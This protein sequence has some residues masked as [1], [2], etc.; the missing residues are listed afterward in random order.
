MLSDC[1]LYSREEFNRRAVG[2]RTSRKWQ[3]R[4]WFAYFLGPSEELINPVSIP[5]FNGTPIGLIF[6]AIPFSS[7]QFWWYST[8]R[9]L[10]KRSFI[11][12]SSWNEIVTEKP[13]DWPL[14]LFSA[15]KKEVNSQIA[16]STFDFGWEPHSAI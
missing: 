2:Y 5:D 8:P 1:L 15:H 11:L 6:G 7:N 3:P 13:R 12:A 14:A 16:L 9:L 10:S 4:K